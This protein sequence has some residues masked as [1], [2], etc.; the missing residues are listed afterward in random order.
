MTD[1]SVVENVTCLGCGCACDDIGVVVHDR[2]IVEARNA[3]PLGVGWFGDG[4]IPSRC[5][6][7]GTEVELPAAI[8]AAARALRAARR[9]LVFLAPGISTEAQ[10]EAAALADVLRAR[11]DSVTSSGA[12]PCVVASQEGGV[13]S[14]TLGEVRN[15][16]DVVVF[17]GIDLQG[18]YPR[19]GSRYA[20]DPVGTHVPDGRRSRTVIAIDV[21][22]A[23]S[24][25]DADHRI[26]IDPAAELATLVA[27]QALVRD[28]ND[29]TRYAS[30]SS[31]PWVAARKLTPPLI[32]A[33]YV[34]L[35]Y[36]AERDDRAPRSAQR[37]AALAALSQSLNDRTRCAAIALRAGGNRSGADAVLVA[38]TG[39]PFAVDFSRGFPRYSPSRHSAL[40]LLRDREVDVALV[41]GEAASLPDE[42]RA[43]LEGMRTVIVGP[44]AGEASLGADSVGIDTGVDGIHVPGTAYRTDDVPLPLRAPLPGPRSTADVLRAMRTGR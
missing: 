42:I 29:S 30:L 11:L 16:G 20:P 5:L 34:A 40:A 44:R 24:T 6:V 23:T 31:P 8:E 39:Y 1:T 33:R 3:C 43:Q 38:Q 9:P 4:R 15:R 12:A 41:V 10:R 17:W 22:A 27:G 28:P 13:A 21:G 2:R 36:D 19:F 7:S 35:V 18:R 32:G 37:F 26:T 14:A 25:V